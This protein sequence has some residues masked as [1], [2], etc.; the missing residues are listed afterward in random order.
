MISNTFALAA[1]SLLAL[2]TANQDTF[3]AGCKFST[4]ETDSE[5][6]G[7]LVARQEKDEPVSYFLRAEGLDS[8]EAYYVGTVNTA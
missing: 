8:E 6:H 5:F 7:V 3:Y 1:T 2:A 4:V